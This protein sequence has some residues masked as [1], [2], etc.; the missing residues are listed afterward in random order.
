MYTHLFTAGK[1][2]SQTLTGNS[3]D[4]PDTRYLPW[5]NAYPKDWCGLLAGTFSSVTWTLIDTLSNES[6]PQTLMCTETDPITWLLATLFAISAHSAPSSSSRTKCQQIV[7]FYHFVQATSDRRLFVVSQPLRLGD[8]KV[9]ATLVVE[10]FRYKV[11]M[12]LH[13]CWDNYDPGWYAAAVAYLYGKDDIEFVPLLRPAYCNQCDLTCAARMFA[14]E[15]LDSTS[16]SSLTSREALKTLLR[17]MVI[18][19]CIIALSFLN[20]DS[21]KKQ[22]K[23]LD[24]IALLKSTIEDIVV[25]KCS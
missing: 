5:V 7:D 13:T 4:P 16:L 23:Q 12:S 20:D 6:D 19:Y 3:S 9:P 10:N 25:C 1:A 15:I 22:Y 14:N 8:R 24:K 21:Q 17:A 18:I 2:L 11:K